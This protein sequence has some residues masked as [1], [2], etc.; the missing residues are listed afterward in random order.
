MLVTYT[1]SASGLI[2]QLSPSSNGAA[3][4][5]GTIPASTINWTCYALGKAVVDGVANN[6]TI[7]AKYT[8]AECR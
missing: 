3:L 6:A 4:A 7:L 8:P 1:A 2:L 5:S